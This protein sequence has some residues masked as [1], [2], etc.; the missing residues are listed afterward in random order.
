MVPL[1]QEVHPLERKEQF[2]HLH[3][4][5]EDPSESAAKEEMASVGNNEGDAPKETPLMPMVKVTNGNV[6]NMAAWFV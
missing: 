3:V 5:R 4:D 2:D 1:Q 6:F